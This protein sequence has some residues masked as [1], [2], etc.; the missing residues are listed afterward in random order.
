MSHT[1]SALNLNNTQLVAI[2]RVDP[3]TL[4]VAQ[5][6]PHGL[7]FVAHLLRFAQARQ[8][9]LPLELLED[10]STA[11]LSIQ[12]LR[13]LAKEIGWGYDTTHRYTKVF[14]VMGLLKEQRNGRAR[15]LLFPLKRY[16]PPPTLLADLDTLIAQSRSKS[17]NKLRILAQ[18]VRERC[19]LFTLSNTLSGPSES[20]SDDLAPALL[21]LG[22]LL[23]TEQVSNSRRQR[24][25]SRM[26]SVLTTCFQSQLKG[27]LEIPSIPGNPKKET[28]TIAQ[29]E[30]TPLLSSDQFRSLPTTAQNLP[31]TESKTTD[32]NKISF[33][34]LRQSFMQSRKKED[35]EPDIQTKSPSIEEKG[36]SFRE[37][38][39]T[40]P[41]SVERKEDFHSTKELKSPNMSKKGDSNPFNNQNPAPF[42]GQ[43]GDPNSSNDISRSAGPSSYGNKGDLYTD[44]H[45]QE[46]NRASFSRQKGDLH[47][48]QDFGESS[49]SM[50]K[51]DS[52]STI[53]KPDLAKKEDLQSQNEPAKP[54]LE[55]VRKQAEAE[56]LLK[57][58]TTE[59]SKNNASE[60]EDSLL[61]N[62]NVDL[63]NFFKTFT[64]RNTETL[65]NFLAQ[66]LEE[67]KTNAPKYIKLIP[68]HSAEH[69]LT[70][71]IWTMIRW[72]R[73][74]GE[75]RTPGAY[76]TV[77]CR[78]YA[79]KGISEIEQTEV[80]QYA[81]C[82]VD[83]FL[84]ALEKG[85]DLNKVKPILNTNKLKG[86][87]SLYP[88]LPTTTELAS[89]STIDEERV[90]LS[91][92]EAKD[93]RDLIIKTDTTCFCRARPAKVDHNKYVVVLDD[94]SIAGPGLR[95]TIIYSSEDFAQR[96][97]SIQ[98]LSDLFK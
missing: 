80:E 15:Y 55:V 18:R 32:P 20:V 86:P 96:L 67:S 40:Q 8:N 30:P 27:R 6:L 44:F 1:I 16:S 7:Q 64:L 70:A 4:Q 52:F 82:T 2:E 88:K 54:A 89:K 65:A 25:I 12:R 13:D 73:D 63:N 76:F 36:D 43:K 19:T 11:V 14:L 48:K 41:P 66:Q 58:L 28:L 71:F 46:G 9:A 62:V 56:K 51:G 53:Q 72:K 34:S 60:N 21:M 5:L 38:K 35:F 26:T 87:L 97:S 94:S 83:A 69:L 57:Q 77:C 17:T 81:H 79:L 23:K 42:L 49:E 68:Q 50:R 10:S 33:E 95:R 74:K 24:I 3:Y 39:M 61:R 91:L 29:H 92:Q 47:T 22:N 84:L 59:N 98:S 37:H 93:L 78:R 85:P 31:F 75:V 90:C 45:S